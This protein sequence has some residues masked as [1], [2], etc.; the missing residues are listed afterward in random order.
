MTAELLPDGPVEES[1]WSVHRAIPPALA[2]FA[3]Y[4]NVDEWYPGDLL[5][6]R[7]I[8]PRG[9]TQGIIELQREQGYAADAVWTHAAMYIGDGLRLV[10]ATVD[11]ALPRGDV[12]LTYLWDYCDGAHAFRV[13]RPLATIQDRDIGWMMVIEALARLQQKYDVL[14]IVKLAARIR[15]FGRKFWIPS[16]FAL[17][18]VPLVC[19]TLY[20]DVYSRVTRMLLAEANGMCMP[21]FLSRSNQFQN[22][23]RLYW[24]KLVRPG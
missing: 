7:K 16:E 15:Y 8:N 17:M 2:D 24:R 10:E 4:P 6:I 9:M 20:A 18:D 14:G 11:S 3:R 22:V 13:R 5:L 19:S 21:A 1:P 23:T 12:R